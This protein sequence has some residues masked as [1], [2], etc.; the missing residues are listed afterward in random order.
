M[1]FH[2]LGIK[3]KKNTHG[4]KTMDM[5][6]YIIASCSLDTASFGKSQMPR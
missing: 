2:L 6:L 5:M 4:E 1:A 3:Q